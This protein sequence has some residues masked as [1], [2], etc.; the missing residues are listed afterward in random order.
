MVT[1]M[2]NTDRK[3]RSQVLWS[4]AISYSFIDLNEGFVTINHE[5]LLAKLEDYRTRGIINSWFWSY[6][7]DR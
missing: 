5:T 1:I 6:L 4:S 2:C 7:T 3:E